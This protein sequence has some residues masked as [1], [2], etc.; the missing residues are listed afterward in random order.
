LDIEVV[1]DEDTCAPAVRLNG[2][3]ARMAQRRGVAAVLASLSHTRTQTIAQAVLVGHRQRAGR[4]VGEAQTSGIRKSQ[5]GKSE[6]HESCIRRKS[7]MDRRT[8]E[9]PI[10]ARS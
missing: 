1:R 8:I 2:K 4:W 10:T 6:S 3:G 7:R 9:K 5:I